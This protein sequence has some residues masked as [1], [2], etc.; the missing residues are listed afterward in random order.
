MFFIRSIRCRITGLA[1]RESHPQA[2]KMSTIGVASGAI[3]VAR[4]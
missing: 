1:S 2:W 3:A 4:F